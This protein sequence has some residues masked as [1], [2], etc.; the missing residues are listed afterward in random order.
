MNWKY[1]HMRVFYR[2]YTFIMRILYSLFTL[3]FKQGAFISLLW[4]LFTCNSVSFF[5]EV[6]TYWRGITER[7][8][9]NFLSDRQYRHWCKDEATALQ[10]LREHNI[11]RQEPPE[12]T[13][14]QG[15]MT[16][17][18]QGARNG[19]DRPPIWRCPSH[20]ER[21]FGAC[22]ASYSTVLYPVYMNTSQPTWQFR[23]QKRVKCQTQHPILVISQIRVLMTHTS[24]MTDRSEQTILAISQISHNNLYLSYHR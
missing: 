18:K 5:L 20:K 9:T 23:S 16:Q 4:L 10:M 1:G 13:I 8:M 6:I 7:N 24:H 12:C 11:I 3:L 15:H 22:S 2:H 19:V 14:C 21:Q 17:V